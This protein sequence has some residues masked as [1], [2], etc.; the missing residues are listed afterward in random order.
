VRNSRARLGDGLL[1]QQHARA[2]LQAAGEWPAAL[3]SAAR[4]HASEQKR[5]FPHCVHGPVPGGP[6]NLVGGVAAS[7]GQEH[8]TQHAHLAPA[9]GASSRSTRCRPHPGCRSAELASP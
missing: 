9:T 2:C 3:P 8:L 7:V 5:A 4:A 6:H 1:A